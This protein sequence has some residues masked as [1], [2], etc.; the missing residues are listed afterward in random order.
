MGERLKPP[1]LK[2]IPPFWKYNKSL[3][4]LNGHTSQLRQFWLL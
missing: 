1:V 2:T 3:K 4:I